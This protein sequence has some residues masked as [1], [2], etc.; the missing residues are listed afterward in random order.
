MEKKTVIFYTLDKCEEFCE[1]WDEI[2]M[3]MDCELDSALDKYE[4]LAE[5]GYGNYRL[6]KVTLSST[7]S[8]YWELIKYNWEARKNE[9]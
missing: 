5:N 6:R 7:H 2:D 1:G 4:F 9:G 3:F 8:F